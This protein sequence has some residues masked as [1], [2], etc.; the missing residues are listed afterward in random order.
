MASIAQKFLASAT[1]ASLALSATPAFARG[2]DL[3]ASVGV[4]SGSAHVSAD[5][6]MKTDGHGTRR[7]WRFG[8]FLEHKAESEV[9]H[10]D[11]KPT[12]TVEQVENRFEAIV[13]RTAR[14]FAKIAKRVCMN[15]QADSVQS[16]LDG[17][18]AHVKASFSAA[19]DAAFTVQ[20]DAN[21]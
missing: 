18:A 7:G 16:C 3:D 1:A 17:I 6:S 4:R 11:E 10:D 21:Q 8:T 19:I 2:L 13:T 5:A 14:S 15:D 20:A 12:R 9:E